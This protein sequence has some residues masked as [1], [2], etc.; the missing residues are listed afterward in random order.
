M[1]SVL[2]SFLT[3]LQ[4]RVGNSVTLRCSAVDVFKREFV[5]LVV[6]Y[7]PVDGPLG[8]EKDYRFFVAVE[9]QQR[10]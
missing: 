2:F 7:G 6:I 4:N 10:S 9:Y 1:V 3:L 5:L 8:L